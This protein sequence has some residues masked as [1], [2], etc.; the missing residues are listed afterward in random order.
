MGIQSW[1]V[2]RYGRDYSSKNQ[3]VRI[4][5]IDTPELRGSA[6]CEKVLARAARDRVVEFV[7]GDVKIEIKGLDKYGRALGDVFNNGESLSETLI[8]EGHGRAY[9]GGTRDRNWCSEIEP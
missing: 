9:D 8:A 7:S 3:S 2:S 5:G 6:E 1:P 4:I